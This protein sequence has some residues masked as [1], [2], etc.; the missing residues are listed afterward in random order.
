M[1]RKFDEIINAKINTQSINNLEQTYDYCPIC[2]E[3]IG[4]TNITIT[5]CGHKFCHVCLDEHSCTNNM[6]PLCRKNMETKI[7]NKNICNCHIRKSVTKALTDSNHHLNNLCKRLIKKFFNMMHK[8]KTEF[9][10][11]INDINNIIPCQDQINT[12]NDENEN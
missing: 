3:K 4:S 10:T 1:K 6:C 9:E 2:M 5:K 12:N 7:K 11:I 8:N